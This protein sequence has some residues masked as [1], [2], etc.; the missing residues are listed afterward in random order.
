MGMYDSFHDTLN[1]KEAQ[2]KCL[3][4]VFNHYVPGDRV[5]VEKNNLP[6]YCTI[7]EWGGTSKKYPDI[8]M[9]ADDDEFDYFGVFVVII[10]GVFEYITHDDKNVIYPIYN[11]Y[12][13]MID[14]GGLE[15]L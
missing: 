4:C 3:D 13:Q 7:A 14:D 2:L 5:P 10:D 8:P 6:L 11:K 1:D 15:S 12:G 9:L